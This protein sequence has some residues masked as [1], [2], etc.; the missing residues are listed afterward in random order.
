[1]KATAKDNDSVTSTTTK[2]N[3][4]FSTITFSTGKINTKNKK[5]TIQDSI[6]H[7]AHHIKSGCQ[8]IALAILIGLIMNGCYSNI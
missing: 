8:I 3:D 6:D 5:Y 7:L 1:M 4:C 2:D